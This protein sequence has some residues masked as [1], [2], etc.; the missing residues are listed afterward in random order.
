MTERFDR[1]IS[2]E[3][4]FWPTAALVGGG[5]VFNS[6]RDGRNFWFL[7]RGLMKSAKGV[8]GVSVGLGANIVYLVGSKIGTI[9]SGSI[10]PYRNGSYWFIGSGDASVDG[11]LVGYAS[12]ILQYN[13]G[14]GLGS[15]HPA[16]LNQ[17]GAPGI[18]A[19]SS[20]INSGT[21]AAVITR[22][23]SVT[24]AESVASLPTTPITVKNQQ[25]KLIFGG[26]DG[27]QDRW[28]IY[29]SNKGRATTGPFF[30][31]M[32]IADSSIPGDRRYSFNF[33]DSQLSAV[34]APTDYFVPPQGTHVATLGP[35]MIVLGSYSGNG[36]A[37][38]V[39][40]SIPNK[41]EAYSPLATSFLNPLESIVG[42][43]ARP[44]E[45]ELLLWTNNS[46]Q[47]LVL[48]GSSSFPVLPRAVWPTTGIQSP[49]G[50]CFADSILYGYSGKAGPV[51]L[52]GAE[53]DTSF[54]KPVYEFIRNEG[55]DASTVIVGYDRERDAVIYVG[56]GASGVLA[57][58]FMRSAEDG[59]M[60]S[61]PMTMPGMPQAAITL[62][63]QLKFSIGGQLYDWEAGS[64]GSAYVLPAWDDAPAAG[65]RKTYRGYR[66]VCNASTLTLDLLLDLSDT[67]VAGCTQTT[68][69]SGPR[70]TPW[71][72]LNK[73]CRQYGVKI[74]TTGPGQKIDEVVQQLWFEPGLTDR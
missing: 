71:K 64:G 33:Y 72:L 52:G 27:G 40:P 48:T 59:R 3:N 55:W 20:G 14:T 7:G 56:S 24:G 19:G 11:A 18:E 67:A 39:S 15:V 21:Y 51:R 70:Q 62:N 13:T 30:H 54:A 45:G 49:H 37:A 38:G 16:G 17:P 1:S 74:S 73:I 2:F 6:A 35:E 60:W 68:T 47:A 50:A 25:I 26:L 63:G 44:T 9:G 5:R 57:L 43:A 28:G 66:A 4:G 34:Q 10:V 29:F 22:I 31:L 69:G 41:P 12:S 36:V 65:D 61:L 32:D 8:G 46:L 23:N 53:P 58:P 42:F